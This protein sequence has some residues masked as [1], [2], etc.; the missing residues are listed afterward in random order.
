MKVLIIAAAGD[1]SISTM[2]FILLD[3]FVLCNVDINHI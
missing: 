3:V 2:L 1:I